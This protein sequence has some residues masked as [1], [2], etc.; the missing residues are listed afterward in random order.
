MPGVLETVA[1]IVSSFATTTLA[2]NALYLGTYALAL[3]GLAFGAQ[4]LQ[5]LFVQKPSVPKPD[6][7]SYNL[8]QSVPS[9]TYVLGTTKKGGDYVFLEERAGYAYHVI[10]WAGHRIDGF[11]QHYFHDE[12]VSINLGGGIVS[13]AHF[14]GHAGIQTR[15]GLDAETAY[16][17]I[18]AA[19][20]TIWNANCRG[21][22]LASVQMWVETVDA[23]AYL[24]IFP[25]QMPQHSAVGN[26]ALLYDPRK[27][28]TQGGAGTHRFTDHNTW[29]FSR[30]IALMRLWHLC[31]PVGGKMKYSDM[32]L[33]DWM[34]AADVCDQAVI[35]RSGGAEARYHGGF[36]FRASNDPIEVG[37]SMDEAAE[38]VVYERA[39]GKI[40]VH[41][42]EFVAPDITLDANSIYSIRV[43]K[44]KRRASTVLGMRGRYV[45]TAKD[46][47]TEDAA[48]YGDPYSD[49]D[50]STERTKTFDNAL[51]QSHNHCQRKQKLTF[52]RLNARK[53]S[54]V[55]DYT[56]GRVREIA[57]RRFVTVHYPSRGLINATVEITSS[58]SIDLRNMRIS[59]SGII[60]PS[61]L[62][63]FNAATE[64]GVP[65]TSVEPLP[66][67]GVPVPVNFVPTVQTE[68]VSGGATA[69]FVKATW[70]LVSDGLTY[71]LEYD[72]VTGSTG[73][74]S[75]FSKAGETQVR[76]G[77]LVDGQ[78]YKVRLRAWGGGSRSDWTDYVTLTATADTV[79]PGA[80]TAVSVSPGSGLALF[81]W[82]APN[83]A[84]YF[85]TRI[86]INTVNNQGT[87]T[88]AATEYGPP[89]AVDQRTIVGLSAGSKY[90]WLVPINSSGVAGPAAATG[91]FT[92]S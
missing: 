13:P 10:V 64:E 4:A 68:V 55:A 63:A 36:W 23:E 33:P 25:N 38:L 15:I 30:N 39:D 2:A 48:I 12:K 84:N 76:S 74:Q 75:V 41:A 17:N 58:V 16:S 86:Y 3:G 54:V 29:A 61:S 77:Y 40:G 20:P 78:Q 69:A 72:R 80:L 79:A 22:G 88:L 24:D 73:V 32:Y 83:S 37:R 65:G 56:A 51:I 5:S 1:L 85:A 92:V 7:G 50:D 87:A 66:N 70:D 89:S 45:N 11:L 60:V 90:A 59:F 6:D 57:Y 42:G 9:L 26:G 43:D 49:V 27:D 71:E 8:K 52:I 53:I 67:E 47:I 91:S 35:N 28:S 44:N 34:N 81:Q 46:Y 19:F 62:Y 14:A 21:D 18:V 82:T 31:H